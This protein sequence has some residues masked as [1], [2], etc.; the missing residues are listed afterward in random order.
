MRSAKIAT[1]TVS[2]RN[3]KMAI[4]LATTSHQTSC[5][6]SVMGATPVHRFALHRRWCG[7]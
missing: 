2:M 3:T 6:K 5:P 7:S 4:A 1:S